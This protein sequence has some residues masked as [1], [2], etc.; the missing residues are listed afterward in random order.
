MIDIHSH[1]LN[2]VDDG[3]E[4]LDN[5]LEILTKA[6]EA[7][8][9][10]IILTPH[11][12]ESYYENTKQMISEKIREL[13]QVLYKEDIII[14]LHHG[15]E[16]FLTD[17]TPIYLQKSVVATLANSRYLLFEIPFTSRMLN[18]EKI[19][20]EMQELGYI[21]VLAHPE[22]Y[23]FVQEDPTQLIK[24]IRMG[25]L[26]QSNYGSFIGFY[27]KDVK[28]TAEI[29]LENRLIHF[30]GSDTHK[31]GHIYENID[32]IL[33]RLEMIC[34]DQRYIDELTTINPRNILND[35][36]IYVECPDCI[37]GKKKVFFLF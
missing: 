21:P 26:A 16:I 17:K 3:S 29:L 5:T 36:D 37:K 13:K 22:R 14:T 10:D 9:S 6:E 20:C 19:I 25:V 34:G 1:I 8:F 32:Q 23:L 33:R 11:Y 7:G 24:L 30:M 4:S 12:I 28:R 31:Q 18:L 2:N 35:F 15:N 27:G